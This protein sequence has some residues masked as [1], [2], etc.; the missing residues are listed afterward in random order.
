MRKA[1]RGSDE[2]YEDSRVWMKLKKNIEKMFKSELPLRINVDI[3]FGKM[4]LTKWT[5]DHPRHDEY[6]MEYAGSIKGPIKNINVHV[7]V[8]FLPRTEFWV[9][10]SNSDPEESILIQ[11]SKAKMDYYLDG[12]FKESVEHTYSENVK[13]QFDKDM[14]ADLERIIKSKKST[15]KAHS[16]MKKS[17]S[18]PDFDLLA[19]HIRALIFDEREEII[20]CEGVRTDLGNDGD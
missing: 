13:T 3:P 16:T 10:N 15:K 9:S 8:T 12:A 14:S 19:N 11:V 20:G 6:K 18:P 2:V 7:R 5:N 1:I 4:E 17:T